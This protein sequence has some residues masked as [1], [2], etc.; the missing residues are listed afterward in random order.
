MRINT[1][2]SAARLDLPEDAVLTLIPVEDL[3]PT[4]FGVPF[5]RDDA[6]NIL[7]EVYRLT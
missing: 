6:V 4:A 5:S 3:D 1:R 7:R 2:S